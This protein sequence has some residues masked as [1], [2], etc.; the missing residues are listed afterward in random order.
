MTSQIIV[1]HKGGF[2]FPEKEIEI[3][4]D[5]PEKGVLGIVGITTRK[6]VKQKIDATEFD[7][8]LGGGASTAWS[9]SRQAL[10]NAEQL[11]VYTIRG[12]TP[13]SVDEMSKVY[14]AIRKSS[15]EVKKPVLL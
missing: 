5:V 9:V 14:E 4:N 10:A 11:I 15:A 8:I 1:E 7:Q 6:C 12:P 13:R 2:S 3:C